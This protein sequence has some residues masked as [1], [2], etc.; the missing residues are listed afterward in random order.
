MKVIKK[1][2]KNRRKLYQ[3]LI[4]FLIVG[5]SIFIN[6]NIN[7]QKEQLLSFEFIFTYLGVF[8]GFSIAIYTFI[9]SIIPSIKEEILKLDLKKNNVSLKM[10]L[11]KLSSALNELKQGIILVLASFV[12]QVFVKLL[13]NYRVC[14]NTLDQVFPLVLPILNLSILFITIVVLI[15]LIKSM[16]GIGEISTILLINNNKNN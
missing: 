10:I 2:K 13:L 12:I 14:N 9:I 4:V 16:F 7:L 6:I 15:D 11:V 8:L 3:I 5:L 1:M